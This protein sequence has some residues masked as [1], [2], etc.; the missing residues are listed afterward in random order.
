M[1]PEI[2][3]NIIT[4]LVI[5]I[6]AFM[7]V[8][9]ITKLFGANRLRAR[10]PSLFNFLFNLVRRIISFPVSLISALVLLITGTKSK[11]SVKGGY[12]CLSYRS[13]AK[14]HKALGIYLS[15][16]IASVVPV[17]LIAVALMFL[18]PNTFEAVQV[19]LESWT[20][21][22]SEPLGIDVAFKAIEV[23]LEVALDTLI[24]G[25]FAESAV[26]F[27]IFALVAALICSKPVDIKFS[28]VLIVPAIAVILAL[29]NFIFGLVSYD[30][31][32]AINTQIN[33]IAMT[34]IFGLI[35]NAAFVLVYTIITRIFNP[36]NRPKKSK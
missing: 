8:L 18:L 27:I 32:S 36:L 10:I 3:S 12:L 15:L 6:V 20:A 29:Y 34:L 26:S 28:R 17:A 13:S 25:G 14:P 19:G 7:L 22:Q 5:L 31:Y 23:F 33:D 21:L 24:L 35:I 16:I 9:F 1:I 11:L 4:Q 2:I 30:T